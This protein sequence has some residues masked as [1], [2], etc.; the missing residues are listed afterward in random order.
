MTIMG[1]EHLSGQ[2]LSGK[3]AKAYKVLKETRRLG[4]M[5]MAGKMKLLKKLVEKH[6]NPP[7]HDVLLD[8]IARKKGL[9]NG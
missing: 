3:D 8:A 5:E 2:G 1:M 9:F 6:G 4:L 7:P